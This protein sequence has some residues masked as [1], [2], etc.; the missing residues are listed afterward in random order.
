MAYHVIYQDHSLSQIVTIR[1]LLLA[2]CPSHRRWLM[3]GQPSITRIRKVGVSGRMGGWHRAAKGR[4]CLNDNVPSATYFLWVSFSSNPKLCPLTA[5]PV[6]VLASSS[7]FS[8]PAFLC[9]DMN[10]KC[11]FLVVHFSWRVLTVLS[12]CLGSIL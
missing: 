4:A 10:T 1:T 3:D 12:L 2:A 8:K 11:E 9:L 7:S 6:A 5:Y